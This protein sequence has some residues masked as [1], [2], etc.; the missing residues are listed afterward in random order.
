MPN[1]T[2]RGMF[3]GMMTLALT[4]ATLAGPGDGDLPSAP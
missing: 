2:M 3:A 4:I 1:P